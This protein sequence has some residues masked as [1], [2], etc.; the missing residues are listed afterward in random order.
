AL[1]GEAL[2][3]RPDDPVLL[4]GAGAAAHEQGKPQD[5]IARLRQAV[6]R[7]PRLVEASRLLGVIAYDQGDLTLAIKTYENALKYAPQNRALHDQLDAWREEQS[8]HSG[9]EERRSDRFR[10]MFEGRAGE[11]LGADATTSL[12]SAFWRIGDTNGD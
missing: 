1:F 11:A 4:F 8:V 5:A 7:N 12:I 6:E 9:F 10:A 3:I 2:T